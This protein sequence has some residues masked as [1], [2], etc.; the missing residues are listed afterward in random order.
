MEIKFFSYS[1]NRKIKPKR[2]KF[3]KAKVILGKILA[4]KSNGPNEK[5]TTI[6]TSIDTTCTVNCHSTSLIY[7]YEKGAYMSIYQ[8]HVA[9]DLAT[10]SLHFY[11]A[12]LR[13]IGV[14]ISR[15]KKKKKRR[16]CH[17]WQQREFN[18]RNGDVWLSCEINVKCVRIRLV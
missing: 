6:T 13:L 7:I 5:K 15:G 3:I 11:K 4:I 9:Y 14:C 2:N 18:H 12:C 1:P 17:T 8:T 10:E 16:K